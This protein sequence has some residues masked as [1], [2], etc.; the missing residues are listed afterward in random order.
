MLRYL[1]TRKI[2]TCVNS[3]LIFNLLILDQFKEGGGGS[4]KYFSLKKRFPRV[5]AFEK[6]WVRRNRK[7]SK[8]GFS[9][10]VFLAQEV[11]RRLDEFPLLVTCAQIRAL[12]SDTTAWLW[13]GGHYT[14]RLTVSSQCLNKQFL[15]ST[16]RTDWGSG[17]S[18]SDFV[19]KPA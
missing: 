8:I 12:L 15:A 14:L 5:K 4:G 11:H 7:W 3:T 1:P 17:K 9:L 2:T 16:L 13:D 6:R 10:R 19:S 18:V